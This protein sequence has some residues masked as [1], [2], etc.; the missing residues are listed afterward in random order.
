[1]FEKMTENSSQL[2][3]FVE[4]NDKVMEVV[5]EWHTNGISGKLD[6]AVG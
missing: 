2:D 5:A 4:Q 3:M 6:T 1:M